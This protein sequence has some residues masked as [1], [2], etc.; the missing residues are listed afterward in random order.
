MPSRS[1]PA[2][3]IFEAIPKVL[4]NTEL[5]KLFVSVVIPVS[6]ARS[7]G[8]GSSEASSVPSSASSSQKSSSLA[9]EIS[10]SEKTM[11]NISSWGSR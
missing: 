6:R 7:T 4:G 10:V 11:S 1:T 9:D 3:S 2:S 5:A 8:M